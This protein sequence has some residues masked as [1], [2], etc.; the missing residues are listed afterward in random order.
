MA[1]NSFGPNLPVPAPEVGISLRDI[2]FVLF[3]R[4]WI[5]LAIALPIILVGAFALSRQTGSYTANARVV[6]EL[7]KVDLPQ[8]NTLGRNLDYDRELSTLLNVGMSLPVVELAAVSLHDSIP[9]MRELVPD[10]IDL[11]TDA[12]LI[13]YLQYGMNVSLVGESTIIDFSFS[14]AHPRI[15]LMAAGALRDAFMQYHVHGR[16]NMQ[17]VAYYE[18]QIHSVRT[19]ID[20]LLN[21]RSN[22]MKKSGYTSLDIEFRYESG[23]IANLQ[24]KLNDASIVRQTLEME[25]N[26]LLKYLDG[27]PRDFPMGSD[28]NKSTTLVVWRNLVTKYEDELGGLLVTHTADS[29]AV[30]RHRGLIENAL[31]NLKREQRNYVNSFRI[32][33]DAAKEKET[34]LAQQIA[35]MKVGSD[36][37]PEVYHE[38]SLLDA[39]IESMRGLFEDLQSKRGEVRLRQ[40]ADERVSSIVI[41]TNPEISTLL[42]GSKTIVYLIVIIMFALALGVVVAFVL[43]NLDHRIYGPR[44]VEENLKL[45]VFASVSKVE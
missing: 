5:I 23:Q 22:V 41:L 10:L 3:R 11:Q 21:H 31:V 7:Q 35:A 34:L 24:A 33:L 39:E 20:S 15:S 2:V 8:W 36:K 45:P 28:E 4:R 13:E 26:S 14:S 40:L 27:D 42:S 37:G 9:V 16:K 25:Y 19:E 6:A 17:A 38:V 44:D 1:G 32:P 43:E 12:D 29:D 30:T 18:E